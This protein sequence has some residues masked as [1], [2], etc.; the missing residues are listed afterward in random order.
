M[1]IRILAKDEQRYYRFGTVDR[2]DDGSGV[3][4]WL[5]HS[6][7][8]TSI[9]V[10]PRVVESMLIHFPCSNGVTHCENARCGI[11]SKTQSM[12]TRAKQAL[13]FHDTPALSVLADPFESSLEP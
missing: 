1:S 9:L 13:R 5:Q 6:A 11:A 3:V 12:A 7:Q 4:L 2:V 8:T 10:M